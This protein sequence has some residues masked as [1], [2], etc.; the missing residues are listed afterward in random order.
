[1]KVYIVMFTDYEDG[2]VCSVWTT[3]ELAERE[4]ARV[5]A[6]LRANPRF[7][8]GPTHYHVEEHEVRS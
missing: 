3:A 8:D 5:D 7:A 4:A 1:M 6:A 2:H